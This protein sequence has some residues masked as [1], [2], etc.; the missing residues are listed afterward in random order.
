MSQS[1]VLLLDVMGTLVHDPFY[2]EIPAFFG[3]SLPELIEAKHPSSWLE[4]ELGQIDESE[5]ARRFFAD[6]RPVDLPK[7]KAALLQ[8]YRFLEGVE[9][10]LEQLQ[11]RGVAMHA[12]SNYAPWYRLIEASVGLSRYLSWSFVS[13][14]TGVRKPDPRAYRGAAEALAR[15]ASAC[16]FVDDRVINCQAAEAVGMTSVQFTDAATLADELARIGLL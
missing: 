4:F 10:L 2:R 1:R 15:P 3:M 11:R 14:D 7:L 8:A 13:C 6:E 9:P 12:L 5:L 16:V